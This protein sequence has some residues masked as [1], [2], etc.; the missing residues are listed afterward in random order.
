[1][2]VFT[3]LHATFTLTALPPMRP[4]TLP[5][6]P[7]PVSRAGRAQDHGRCDRHHGAGGWHAGTGEYR[8]VRADESASDAGVHARAYPKSLL[9][10]QFKSLPV[11]W[12]FVD[13]RGKVRAG[14]LM[15][16]SGY[17]QLDSLSVQLLPILELRPARIA[18]T[19]AGVW[20]PFPIQVPPHDQLVG[21]LESAGQ[22]VSDAPVET[23]YT[24]KP[25]LLNRTQVED[26]IV[27]VIHQVDQRVAE[28]SE[29]FA[30]AQR[31]GG[32]VDMRFFIDV[33][34]SVKNAVIVRNG[35]FGFELRIRTSDSN[36]G[37]EHRI[38]TSD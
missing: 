25:I 19:A 30:R 6:L 17:A 13:E 33:D 32:R 20:V 14:R 31:V 24:Q 36:T 15:T 34:G 9:K 1:M 16:G 4:D 38:R 5:P 37:F 26:A 8:A 23:E 12:M 11:A 29:A 21:M 28:M 35:D 3:I 2:H 10:Y 7:V 18:G 22:Q 27:R